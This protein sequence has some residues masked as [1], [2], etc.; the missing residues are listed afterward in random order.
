M[1][2]N[3]AK[4]SFSNIVVGAAYTKVFFFLNIISSLLMYGHV[5]KTVIQRV[6]L[7]GMELYINNED[8][9]DMLNAANYMYFLRNDS[10][11]TRRCC[12]VLKYI[13]T[14]QIFAII[15]A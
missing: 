9:D 3:T 11:K 10:G 5:F 1:C 15:A 12:S 4:T 14:I 6:L 7:R 8:A 2:A 13:N